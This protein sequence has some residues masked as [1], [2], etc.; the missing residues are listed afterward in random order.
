MAVRLLLGPVG[1]GKTG[2]AL[3][4]VQA[5][6]AENPLAQVWVIIASERQKIAFRERM[7]A[8]SRGYF[9]VHFFSF[10]ELYHHLA[11]A[12]GSPRRVLHSGPRA[13]LLRQLLRERWAEPGAIFRP[14]PGF[15]DAIARQFDELRQW[16]I[17]PEA[18]AG[19]AGNARQAELALLFA[20]Y[21]ERLD[22]L[23]LTGREGLAAEALAAVR[24]RPELTAG[25]DGLVVD[26]FD[27]LNPI[28]AVLIAELAVRA[29][30]ALITLTRPDD[31]AVA[32]S[33]G[34]FALAR[35]RLLQSLS[36]TGY[37]PLPQGEGLGVRAAD[38][39][40]TIEYLPPATA[41][42]PGRRAI[43]HLT[44]Q[45]WSPL[46]VPAPAPQA[47]PGALAAP[48][49]S[50]LEAPDPATETA[51]VLR[52][53]KA[54]LLGAAGVGPPCRPDDILIAVRD[55]PRYGP[56][57]RA[58]SARY[59]LPV[60]LHEGAPLAENPAVAAL[61]RLLALPETGYRRLDVIDALRTPY[62]RVPGFPDDGVLAL[63]Q[64][65]RRFFVVSGREEWLAALGALAEGQ[66]AAP[67]EDDEADD[68]S[69]I[70]GAL[71]RSAAETRAALAGLF[72]QLEMAELDSTGAFVERLDSWLGEDEPE[73]APL[74][75]MDDASPEVTYTLGLLMQVGADD[76]DARRSRDRKAAAA[77]K[78]VLRSMRRSAA[79]LTR[80]G[81]VPDEPVSR[82]AFMADLRHETAAATLN[83]PGGRD[84]R[85]LITTAND[86]RG[87]AHRHVFLPG[88]S[89]GIFPSPVAEDPLLLES[90]RQLL[91]EGGLALP[92][93]AERADDTGLFYELAGLAGE[94]LTLSRPTLRDGAEWIASALW[95][96]A[97]AAF[98]S[99]FSTALGVGAVVP[100]AESA[101]REEAALAVADALRS[102]EPPLNGALAG[103]LASADRPA[104]ERL[105]RAWAVETSR[106]SRRAPYDAFSGRLEDEGW[107]S[108]LAAHFGPG[109]G[110]SASQLNILGECG[111]RFFSR[112][113]LG[114]EAL[115][116][117][118]VGLDVRQRGSLLHGILEQTYRRVQAEELAIVPAN[119]E[120]ALQFL[121]DEAR[122]AF[123]YA[124]RRLGFRPRP[125]W[126]QEQARMHAQLI[127]LIAADFSGEV[128]ANVLNGAP[129]PSG[130]E[131]FVAELEGSY[132][133]PGLLR[134]ADGEPVRVRGRFDR[135]DRQ[136][137]RWLVVDY[138]SGTT[139]I[140]VKETLRGRN[141]QMMIYLLALRARQP[142]AAAGGFF[143]HLPK[144]TASG[145]LWLDTP[146]GEQVIEEGVR[147]I[148]RRIAEAR[149]GDF[150]VEPN[151]LDEGR[152]SRYCEYQH[153]CR[154]TVTARHK[155]RPEGDHEQP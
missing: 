13:A 138:K 62:L 40:L 10:E 38:G 9:N 117:P 135:I 134:G 148:T 140:D 81:I 75:D 2:A 153:L 18:F 92:L 132:D 152:C 49:V 76:D 5:L 20:R 27:Q 98:E 57:L 96:A 141:F 151:G 71:R 99:P 26:G 14:L 93:R 30:T 94:T 137:D 102:G 33:S 23:N 149:R 100:A 34:R 88:L 53:V 80:L 115:E 15:T 109:Y 87:L 128:V 16:Q 42:E 51:A 7:L 39:A 114:L 46:P 56:P 106:L 78:N 32:A 63:E 17:T 136:G 19:H 104:W 24:A 111:F 36:S 12:A 1:A 6:K 70:P 74:E 73:S 89:E 110:W 97:K 48:G 150:S 155:Q 154:M 68:E 125:G 119:L 86:A 122:T 142:G 58:L 127:A 95:R 130:G 29:R 120:R 77:L 43:R 147:H 67:G 31:E 25:L 113:L 131:R 85:V 82:A 69:G 61:L 21:Q 146:G 3:A 124:P 45:L 105:H 118:Q 35:E 83:E 37:S 11:G 41:T 84:G 108:L 65:S 126:V 55:W 28:H 121:A 90:E 123:A 4:H 52:R 50:F 143:W 47:E 59:G 79:M 133:A 139:A 129:V 72:E 44:S 112:R 107:Q 8:A 103:W 22:T 145:V 54:L 64:A 101:H 144:Q 116:P 91:R 60:S 66:S